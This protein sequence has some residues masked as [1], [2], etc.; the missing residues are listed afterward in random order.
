MQLV[1]ASKSGAPDSGFSSY[2][3]CEQGKDMT[4]SEKVL[5]WV[6]E[7]RLVLHIDFSGQ[8]PLDKGG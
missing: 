1:Q 7:R 5:Q 2:F 6:I 4:V 3:R 8:L